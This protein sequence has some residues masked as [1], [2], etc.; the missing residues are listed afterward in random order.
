MI[1]ITLALNGFIFRKVAIFSIASIKLRDDLGLVK[2]VFHM[3]S[4]NSI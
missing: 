4:G 1:P 2:K 3:L